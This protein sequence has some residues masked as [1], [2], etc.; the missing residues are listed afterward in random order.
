MHPT[1][2][3]IL[4]SFMATANAIDSTIIVDAGVYPN[5]VTWQVE[6]D[7]GA[8]AEESGRARR[9][10]SNARTTLEDDSLDPVDPPHS[11]PSGSERVR[12]RRE[13]RY[14][15]GQPHDRSSLEPRSSRRR[16]RV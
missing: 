16:R 6:C 9:C 2:L 11:V 7:G 8:S 15:N 4:L 10:E 3:I 14:Q 5:E 1:A 12:R 13:G